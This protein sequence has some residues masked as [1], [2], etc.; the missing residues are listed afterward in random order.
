MPGQSTIEAIHLVRRLVDQYKERKKDLHVVFID[1]EKAYDKIPREVLWRC[2]EVSSVQIAYIRVNKDMYEGAKTPVPWCMLLDDDIV[3]IDEAQ[4]GVSTRLEVW[5]QALESKGFKLNQSKTEYLECKFSNGM[6]EA[7]VEVKTNTQVI[8][9]RDSFKNLGSIIQGNK[10][11]DEDVTHRIGAGWMR[12]RLDSGVLCD[13]NMPPRLKGKFYKVVGRLTM[14]YG[15][16]CWP[17]KTI[18]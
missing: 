15:A 7:K 17:V 13:K 10:E 6:H 18:K 4:D 12:W 14:L 8:P 2:L 11:I 9:K 1:L 3:L 5:R 16:E